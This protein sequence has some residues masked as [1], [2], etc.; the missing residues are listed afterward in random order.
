MTLTDKLEGH[1]SRLE[2]AGSNIQ[3]M[4]NVRILQS[5]YVERG[6]TSTMTFGAWLHGVATNKHPAYGS[7]TRAIRKA[8]ENNPQWR[9]ISSAKKKQVEDVAKEAGYEN[10]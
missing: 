8:R 6:V 9:K 7:I 1:M 3:T 2:T 10:N 4:S 5:Y